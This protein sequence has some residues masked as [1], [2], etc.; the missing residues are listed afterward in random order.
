MNRGETLSLS[1]AVTKSASIRDYLTS[2]D[3]MI[4]TRLIEQLVKFIEVMF[5]V[6]SFD[7]MFRS[8]LTRR[9]NG[10]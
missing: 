10:N 9:L 3:L 4:P 5:C 6:T 7:L 1:S 2:F 8:V